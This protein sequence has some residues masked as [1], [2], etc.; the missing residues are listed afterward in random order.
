MCE[1]SKQLTLAA[2]I[3]MVMPKRRIFRSKQP[4]D[5]Q[6][7]FSVIL[8]NFYFLVGAGGIQLGRSV[9]VV[10]PS[11]AVNKIRAS[12]PFT[13]Y[14]GFKYRTL[15]FMTIL[16]TSRP[17][18]LLHNSKCTVSGGHNHTIS[19]YNNNMLQCTIWNTGQHYLSQSCMPILTS[20]C[21]GVFV[22]GD[23]LHSRHLLPLQSDSADK[24]LATGS[25]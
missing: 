5:V 11:Y 2:G 4:T 13:S 9:R 18:F 19:T 6:Y 1:Y 8:R 21:C 23:R 17:P 16:S 20:L 25:N 24:S 22:S 10:L 3:T 14:A 12:F 7:S 15:F